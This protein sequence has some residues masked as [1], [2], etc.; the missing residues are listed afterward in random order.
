MKKRL[1][2]KIY[3]N[4]VRKARIQ[5]LNQDLSL[6]SLSQ[7]R[8]AET[9]LQMATAKNTK[10][11]LSAVPSPELFPGEARFF[12][13]CLQM[14]AVENNCWASG[15]GIIHLNT[16]FDENQQIS[17]QGWGKNVIFSL[18]T[19]PKDTLLHSDNEIH[20]CRRFLLD[21]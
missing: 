20:K 3:E 16:A 19:S 17:L 14:P 13:S 15:S 8:K 18:L 1:I 5:Y 12:S 2:R 9:A 4:V 10:L 11:P 7:D 21:S 6:P